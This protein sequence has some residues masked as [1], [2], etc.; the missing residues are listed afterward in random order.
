MATD[1]LVYVDNE[2]YA[3]Q[4][5]L[6][7]LLCA[8][9]HMSNGFV[10]VYSDILFSPDVLNQLMHADKD[11]VLA[12][13]NSYQYHRHEVD[14]QLDLVRARSSEQSGR[15]SLSTADI[16]E[17]LAVGKNIDAG[18]ADHE[19]IG[20]AYFS[21]QGARLL[22]EVYDDC[23]GKNQAPFHEAESIARGGVTDMIQE[24]IDRNIP[25]YG[26][27]IQRGWIEVHNKEDV[28]AAEMEIAAVKQIA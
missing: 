22:Q 27:E 28:E 10:M 3:E 8:R 4:H 15:R 11:I 26:R 6:Y 23:V 24:L 13:D 12:I 18:Q 14:K 25:V 16:T 20:I 5:S 2:R 17:V 19:F 9:E 7:S 1:A 21:E